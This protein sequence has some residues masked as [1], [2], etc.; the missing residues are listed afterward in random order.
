MLRW[1]LAVGLAA[2]LI[3]CHGGR[4]QCDALQLD[5]SLSALS[6]HPTDATGSPR[7]TKGPVNA[8]LCCLG[9][10]SPG[11]SCGVDCTEPLY[12]QGHLLDLP[13]TMETY[14]GYPDLGNEYAICDVWAFQ[15]RVK[16]VWWA[17]MY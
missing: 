14:E 17:P 12:Q 1:T 13:G 10:R 5:T 2:S 16:A 9:C 7:D 6:T 3:A 8:I 11:C 4:A 15:E